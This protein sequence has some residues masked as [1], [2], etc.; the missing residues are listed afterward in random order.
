VRRVILLCILLVALAVAVVTPFGSTDA[1][2][3][4]GFL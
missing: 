1:H 4:A 2:A 3:L